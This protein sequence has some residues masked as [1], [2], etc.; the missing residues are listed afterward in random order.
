MSLVQISFFFFPQLLALLEVGFSCIYQEAHVYML[1][2]DR[3]GRSQFS[4]FLPAMGKQLNRSWREPE[5][6]RSHRKLFGRPRVRPPIAGPAEGHK[7]EGR[8]ILDLCLLF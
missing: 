2:A 4:G 5:S 8:S 7:E 3:D 6:N 1:G